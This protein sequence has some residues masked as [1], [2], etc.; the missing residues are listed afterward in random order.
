MKKYKFI[1]ILIILYIYTNVIF[2]HENN[3]N[4]AVSAN[5]L[6]TF[7]IIA[8]KFEKNY[9]CNLI[10]STDSTSSLFKKI[11]NGAPFDIFISADDKHP[12][13]IEKNKN[14]KYKSKIYA[15][16]NLVIWKKKNKIKKNILI[17]IKKYTNISL[18]HS[19]LSP[20]GNASKKIYN[21]LNIKN[22]NVILGLNI[23]Q[24]FNFIYSENSKIGL[25]ALS[26]VIHNKI[27][28]KYIWKIP[29][30]L[31]PKI[32]QRI[33]L[34]ENLKTNKFKKKLLTYMNTKEIKKIIKKS[35]YK[36]KND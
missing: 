13:L 28:K 17:N 23:N 11:I 35:G 33:I 26:Q 30:Y 16:G 4:I 34:I 15:Y 27:K 20:Y 32:E 9:N 22:T 25:I 6:S 10:I 14:Q 8:K 29:P 31:Y 3:L 18:A 2:T 1:L 7:K 24:T 5:F 12:I 21:N 19:K 36:I